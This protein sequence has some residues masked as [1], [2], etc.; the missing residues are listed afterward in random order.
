MTSL[1]IIF[2]AVLALY[3]TL[4]T[5]L[6]IISRKYQKGDIS[7]FYTSNQRLRGFLAAMTYAATTYSSFMIVGLVGFSYFT[8]VGSL[9]FELAYYIATLG[10]L[11]LIAGKVWRQAKEKNWVS[12][13]QMLADLA[14]SRKLS[15]L[16]SIVYLVALVPYA[17]A[18]LKAIGEVIA[19]AG[20][21]E[22]YYLIGI[23]IGLLVM[24]VW[25]SLAGIW[26]VAITDALQGL[27]MIIASL[28]LLGWII[29]ILNSNGLTLSNT[30]EILSSRGLLSVGTGFWKPEIFLA[31]TLPW[32]FFAVTNPQ[33]VQR[34]YM[35]RDEK[36]LSTMIKWFAV[37]GLSYTIIVTLI[38]LLA[39]AGVE[40]GII[41]I[42]PESKDQ[43]TPLLLT[44]VN[45]LLGAIVF[46]SI[47]AASVST[48]D[49]ILLTLAS[50]ASMDLA[51]DNADQSTRKRIGIIAILI[52]GLAM[53]SIAALRI[54][55]I[56]GLSVL[57][58]VMLIG[59]APTTLLLI[60]GYRIKPE[61]AGASIVLPPLAS[62]ILFAYWK[63]PVKVFVYTV[64][65]APISAWLLVAST[66]IAVTGILLEKDKA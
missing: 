51:P 47:I 18:Q 19:A 58:S 25:S 14:G 9:G 37:F 27:W 11:I 1:F 46:T 36:S 10:L 12:P 61:L 64:S 34:L 57:S 21:G 26:S 35:P 48:A 54:S 29:G 3:L 44:I 24:L 43:V 7:D 55:Y 59:L 4:G 41:S 60:A 23:I 17:S 15:V 49:S 13:A 65:G 66:I 42:S 31:F 39:R 30:G 45:P 33:V 63:N 40:A 32:I 22:H 16:I 6:A 56:V 62:V 20:G 38:G 5:I 8:G 53:A 2:L 28:L 52:V 50:T